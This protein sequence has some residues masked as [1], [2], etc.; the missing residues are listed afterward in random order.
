MDTAIARARSWIGIRAGM[1]WWKGG[2]RVL[3]G[4]GGELFGFEADGGY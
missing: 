4:K 3:D 1:C 2:W